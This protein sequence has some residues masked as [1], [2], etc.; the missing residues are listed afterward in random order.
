MKL[1]LLFLCDNEATDNILDV[2]ESTV[3]YNSCVPND[4]TKV[5]F[6]FK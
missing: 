6:E 2:V 3:S 1:F 5:G 4:L